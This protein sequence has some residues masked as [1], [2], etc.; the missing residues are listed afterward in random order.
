MGKVGAFF[1]TRILVGYKKLWPR[2]I[3]QESGARRNSCSHKK[4]TGDH[5]RRM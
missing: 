3:F 1:G 4:L 5:L 2:M